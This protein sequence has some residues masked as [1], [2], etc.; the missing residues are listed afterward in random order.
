MRGT[1]RRPTGEYVLFQAISPELAEEYAKDHDLVIIKDP[2]EPTRFD[3]G[4]YRDM[5]YAYSFHASDSN[6]YFA[7][8]LEPL[9]TSRG[10]ML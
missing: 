4:N 1:I 5:L 7:E 10:D 3:R 8:R 9:D 6:Y 2:P